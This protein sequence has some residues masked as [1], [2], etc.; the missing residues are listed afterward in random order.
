MFPLPQHFVF[1][2]H[3][4]FGFYPMVVVINALPFTTLTIIMYFCSFH[5]IVTFENWTRLAHVVVDQFRPFSAW[6]STG[7]PLESP[8]CRQSIQ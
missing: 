3:F 2:H 5:T 4:Q 6:Q 8:N 1:L 7:E